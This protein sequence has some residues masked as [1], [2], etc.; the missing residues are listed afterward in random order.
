MEPRNRTT[1]TGLLLTVLFF[2]GIL[3]ADAQ[4]VRGELHI[5]V[6]DPQGATLAADAELS[7][8]ANQFRRTF[9]IGSDGRYVVQGLVF[10]RYR[11]SL[12]AKGF[13]QWTDVVE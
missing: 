6:R 2:A 12:R 4:R 10:G 11:L 8:E 13:A 7:S 5:E 9:V 1:C 3:T